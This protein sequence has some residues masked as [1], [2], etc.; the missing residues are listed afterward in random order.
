MSVA[1]DEGEGEAASEDTV[2]KSWTPLYSEQ[3]TMQPTPG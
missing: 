1:E 2:D 3:T